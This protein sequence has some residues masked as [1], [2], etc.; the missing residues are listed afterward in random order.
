MISLTNAMKSSAVQTR[1]QK[2]NDSP[3]YNLNNCRPIS[4]TNY[5]Y[6]ILA[7]CLA[8]KVNEIIQSIVANNHVV[9]V[10]VTC[11]ATRIIDEAIE[12]YKLK[13]NPDIIRALNFRK[14]FD[15]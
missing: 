7:K 8:S 10:I 5:D 15:S 14:S 3:K 1:T 6:Q 12:L 9:Y 4:L 11:V 2:G 13:E